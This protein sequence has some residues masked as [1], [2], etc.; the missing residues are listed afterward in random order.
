VNTNCFKVVSGLMHSVAMA[1]QQQQ[2]QQQQEQHVLLLM[3]GHPG[4]G[5]STL[6]R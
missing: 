4:V 3:K 2:Q 6:A 1:V 5:K